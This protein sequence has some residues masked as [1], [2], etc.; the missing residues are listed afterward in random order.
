MKKTNWK[1]PR[2]IGAGFL[3]TCC[4]ISSVFARSPEE[5][6][7]KLNDNFSKIKDAQA[8]VMLDAGIQLLG[9]GG[10][11]RQKGYFYFKAPDKLKIQV[12]HETYFVNGNSIRK[13]DGEGKRYYVRLINAPDFSAGFNPGIIT[14]NFNLKII[15]ETSREVVL[16]GTP[17]PGVLRNVKKVIFHI[18]PQAALLR[19]M[20]LSMRQGISG[21]IAIQYV[22]I[23]GIAA[24]IATSGKSAVEISRNLLAGLLFSF[25]GEGMKLNAGLSDE[26]FDPGF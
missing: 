14:H 17:K 5:I 7:G 18:D 8:A 13:I 26:L 20:D 15:E 24:P 23:N 6:V 16:E 3:L 21:R 25:K 22:N 19:S 9:C 11:N 10:L 2:L 1:P 12:D 4:L